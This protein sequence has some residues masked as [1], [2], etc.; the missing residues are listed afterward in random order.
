MFL[1]RRAETVVRWQWIGERLKKSHS[2]L[3][4]KRYSLVAAHGLLRIL[5][6]TGDYKGTY[7]PAF[8]SSRLFDALF[9]R[10]T[11]P[12]IDALAVGSA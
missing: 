1:K 10:F 5:Q 4:G 3:A 9:R 8:N 7:S 6:R 11:Q 12:Q 2:V